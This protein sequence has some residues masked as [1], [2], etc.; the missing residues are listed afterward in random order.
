MRAL[1]W[2]CFTLSGAAALALEALWVRSAGLVLGTTASTTATVLAC[3]FAGLG[4]GA[5]WARRVDRRPVRTYGLLEAGAALGALWSLAVFEGLTHEAAQ[6][7]LSLLGQAGRI[8]AVAVAILPTTVCLGATLP[9]LGQT[10]AAS[11]VGRR[12][13]LLY[14][15]NTL[16]GVL[17]VGLAGFG[18]PA[19]IG[20]RASYVAAA[21]VSLLAGAVAI[22]VGDRESG[23]PLTVC[24]DKSYE[25]TR[26]RRSLRLVACCTGGLGL[27]LQVLWTLL[28]A[29]VLHNSIYSFTA[30]VMVNLF[31][32]ATGAAL[33]SLLLRRLPPG[34]VASLALVSAAVATIAGLWLFVYWTDGLAYFGMKSGLGEYLGRIVLLA[35][36]TVGPAALASGAI[37]PSLWALWGDQGGAAQPLGDLSA[38]NLFGGVFGAAIV[39]ILMIPGLG[40]RESLLA[41][42]VAY[43]ILADIL[44]AP[45][46]RFRPLAYASLLAIVVANPS[47]LSLVHLR[48]E[49]ETLRAMAEGTSGIVT[50]VQAGHNLRLRLNNY[51]GLGG[52][53]AEK[54]QRRQGLLPLL[55]HPDPQ[56][57]AFV[58]LATGIT[59]SAGPALG[60]QHTTVVEL[61]PE[62]AEAARMHFGAWN[63][64]LLERPDVRLII[65]DGR[66][67]LAASQER[68]EVIVSDLFIP[69]HAG[70][71]S[72][73]AQEMFTIAARRLTADGLFCQWLPLY[74]LTREEFAIIAQ[75]LLSVFPGVSLWRGD[76]LPK[77]PIVALVGH[78]TPQAI[79][80]ERMHERLRHVPEWGRDQ[81]LASPQ[82]VLMLYAGYLSSVTDLFAGVP[83]NSDDRPVIE[84]LAPRRTRTTADGAVNWFVGE[85]LAAFYDLLESRLQGLPDPLFAAADKV[86]A[87]RRGG[88]ALYRHVLASAEG[89]HEAARRSHHEAQRLVPEVI[90]PTKGTNTGASLLDAREELDD[91]RE[92][93]GELQQRLEQMERRIRMMEQ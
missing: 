2:C 93:Q 11:A 14:A 15:F 37:M 70:S 7:W 92:Q 17:G 76:F 10:L 1:L 67:Y 62:V 47:R 20:V 6:A 33:A 13:G 80:L 38:A 51:Y 73:Y 25:P 63:R 42:A 52:S 59:A 56:R 61:V 84:F 60:V 85:S 68:Y 19:F 69:W 18:L 91:L 88:L 39:G 71:G 48:S 23:M 5:V 77:R 82:R 45:L 32:L 34:A 28:F 55:L 57:V 16:G 50:V 26:S 86:A 78:R 40:I 41:A 30:I 49:R 64:R 22:V 83:I 44:S 21:G 72:L 12:G 9:A 66:R 31:A 87:A 53:G 43:I 27:G 4:L 89:D 75:T 81:L 74:Q 3:Y 35:M 79:D 65:D 58:G 46:G 36:A 90:G 29:Q 24:L 8:F 54:N